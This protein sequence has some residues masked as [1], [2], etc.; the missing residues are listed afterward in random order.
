MEFMVDPDELVTATYVLA[1]VGV[2]LSD[3]VAG[4][5][6]LA[7]AGGRAGVFRG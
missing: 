7:G 6:R 4:G 5:D 1:G 3:E 2:E